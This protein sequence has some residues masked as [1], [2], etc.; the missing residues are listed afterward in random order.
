MLLVACAL[1]TLAACGAPAPPTTTDPDPNPD[2][3]P[4][5]PVVRYALVT[6]LAVSQQAISS[7]AVA[8]DGRWT[9][10]DAAPLPSF[11]RGV[12]V[13]PEAS[14]AFVLTSTGAGIAS[15]GRYDLADDGRFAA[16]VPLGLASAV[17]PRGIVLHPDGRTLYVPG[18]DGTIWQYALGGG[19][20]LTPLDPPWVGSPATGEPINDL[21]IH[22]SGAFAFATHAAA[23]MVAAF[24]IADDGSLTPLIDGHL[25]LA[26]GATPFNIGVSPRG[27]AIYVTAVGLDRVLHVTV[28]DD[29][30]LTST[31]F[32]ET[33]PGS[34][35]AAIVVDPDGAN[36]YVAL[37]TM[38]GGV[39]GFSLEEDGA[40]S[41]HGGAPIATGPVPLTLVLDPSG[42]VLHVV[43][44][45]GLAGVEHVAIGGDGSLQA[46]RRWPS[47]TRGVPIGLAFV[48]GAERPVV[49]GAFAYFS[50]VDTS[51]VT[52]FDLSTTPPVEKP[53]S[54]FAVSGL[55]AHPSGR[56]LYANALNRIDSYNVGVD[57]GLAQTIPAGIDLGLQ[58]YLSTI[59]PVGRF[60]YAVQPNSDRIAILQ[61]TFDGTL[62]AA[63]HVDLSTGAGPIS[64]ALHPS[65]R[66][67]YVTAV[68]ANAVYQF[69]VSIE[70]MLT[71][72]D[73]PS[74]PTATNPLVL[75][76]HPD[77]LSVH[78]GAA[79]LTR[80]TVADDGALVATVPPAIASFGVPR[81]LAMDPHGRRLH[82]GLFDTGHA[83][84]ASLDAAG[85]AGAFD[86][87][88]LSFTAG[89]LAYA[90]DGGRLYAVSMDPHA[91]LGVDVPEDGRLA[92]EPAFEIAV[93]AAT[94]VIAVVPRWR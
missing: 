3:T 26:T 53:S 46:G 77:G 6:T 64:I 20:T 4:G 17:N 74:V 29:G 86:T 2:P 79:S 65:G 60:L 92:A 23:D 82:V 48:Q 16:P 50:R 30:G 34:Q 49:E 61:I 89:A 94:M 22:P 83:Y 73:P 88:R 27:D 87:P 72:L 78:V 93:P 7:Y 1:A 21:A 59:D 51:A 35:P 76:V 67:A 33:P 36:A 11:A 39:L 13:P 57:G 8:A 62:A 75:A 52:A 69:A 68:D 38:D 44:S 14:H 45:V 54:A 43:S 32:A 5:G 15:F 40:L 85:L 10:V 81:A 25:T 37:A 55:A 66:Y 18:G 84:G 71:P 80:F 19:G 9:F 12:V 24:S 70:G 91:F 47:P 42:R 58:A 41:A 63:G 31:G 90:P 56:W 28:A